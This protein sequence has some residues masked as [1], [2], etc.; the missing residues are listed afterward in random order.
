[1]ETLTDII[2]NVTSPVFKEGEEI[3]SKYTCDGDNINPPIIF[4]NLPENSV[5]VAIIMED[6]DA[7]KGTFDHWLVWNISANINEITEDFI[8][9]IEGKNSF[10]EY[11]YGG[12][13]PPNG[14]HRYFFYVYALDITLDLP[15]ETNK[16]ELIKAMEGHVLAEGHLM[17]RYTKR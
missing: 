17:G 16:Q 8:P 9:G 4:N 12:P 1:M 13:C 5:S 10:G 11:R 15:M 2:I 14:T 3:P 7:P 6:P